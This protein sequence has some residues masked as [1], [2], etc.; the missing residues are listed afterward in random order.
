MKKV[1]MIAL[2]LVLALALCTALLYLHKLLTVPKPARIAITR[3]FVISFLPQLFAI[4]YSLSDS[5]VAFP[6]P[7]VPVAGIRFWTMRSPARSP[8]ASA[9]MP[10]ATSSITRGSLTAWSLMRT[11]WY[12]PPPR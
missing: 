7:V 11:A 1:M 8:A 3:Y 12:G 5:Y 6:V 4:Y 9:G 10:T 2:A